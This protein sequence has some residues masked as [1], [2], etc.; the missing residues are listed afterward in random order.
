MS[1]NSALRPRSLAVLLACLMASPGCF[2][3]LFDIQGARLK[4][5]RLR[6][7]ISGLPESYLQF[8]G[9]GNKEPRNAFV[10]AGYQIRQPF[11]VQVQ[12][13]I[14]VPERIPDADGQRACMEI[15][16]R[17]DGTALTFAVLCGDYFTS[18]GGYNVFWFHNLDGATVTGPT[19]FFPG[20]SV[21]FRMTGDG[22]DL[23]FFARSPGAMAWTDLGSTPYV[24]DPGLLG[25][26]GANFLNKGGEIGF[27]NPF[28]ANGPHPRV[29]R[30]PFD[31]EEIIYD[32]LMYA[33]EHLF[34]YCLFLE[35]GDFVSA[36]AELF[37]AADHLDFALSG[38]NTLIVARGVTAI[39]EKALKKAEK[40]VA[41]A[42]SKV[43]KAGA[44]LA[45]GKTKPAGKQGN[46]AIK[47]ADKAALTFRPFE[48]VI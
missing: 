21:D 43:D 28:L 16:E 17:P 4:L 2:S 26:V 3:L 31:P 29:A 34:F 32:E 45:V 30:G 11:D 41:K 48:N 42:R 27:T 40:N 25:S 15:D 36:E 44:K 35:L 19:M 7:P 38:I 33:E 9:R 6:P 24:R 20:A 39:D 37:A 23:A 13:G 14:Y 8:R 12:A 5:Q 10:R 1:A 47:K 18:L 46:A 22:V